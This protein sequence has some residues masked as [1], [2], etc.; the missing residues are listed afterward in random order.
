MA[1]IWRD[2]IAKVDNSLKAS[3]SNIAQ[4]PSALID[5]WIAVMSNPAFPL[6]PVRR[7]PASPEN[8]E[9]AE[10]RLGHSLPEQV[11][12]LYESTDGLAWVASAGRPM[13]FG[14]HF[15]SID[16]LR[17]AGQLE[18]PF[19]TQLQ[20]NWVEFDEPEQPRNIELYGPA[21]MSHIVD[22]PQHIFSFAD[23]DEF[24]ALQ[25]SN[26]ARCI[27][28]AHRDG[29]GVPVGVVLAV[30]SLLATRYESLSHWISANTS[31]FP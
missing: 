11:R 16:V 27:L 26:D 10:A 1:A 22:E 12:E 15:P 7:P 5:A 19:S 30:E 6:R 28:I 14:G 24:L 23:M 8:L 21:V 20:R 31:L 18:T 13:S 2:A 25:V 17:L 9:A 29:L 3:E 4:R